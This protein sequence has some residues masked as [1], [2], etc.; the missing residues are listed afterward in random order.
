M[1]E[2]AAHGNNERHQITSTPYQNTNLSRAIH[3]GKTNQRAKL[4]KLVKFLSVSL[5]AQLNISSK[6]TCK[7]GFGVRSTK[8]YV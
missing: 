4:V 7:L 6:R 2:P 3:S 8:L 1:I 5:L